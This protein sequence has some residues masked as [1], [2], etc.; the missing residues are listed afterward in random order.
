MPGPLFRLHSI[1]G[2]SLDAISH[3]IQKKGQRV[4]E[5]VVGKVATG[6]LRGL[7]YLHSK[8]VV[9]RG[10]LSS[11]RLDRQA[12]HDDFALFRYQAI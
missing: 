12:T 9:H 3:Q 11:P 2:G 4:S 5:K 1:L 7:D 10:T 8:Q 6:I